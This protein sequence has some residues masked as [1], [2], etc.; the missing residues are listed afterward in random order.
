MESETT[1]AWVPLICFKQ[2]NDPSLKMT[3]VLSENLLYMMFLLLFLLKD[4]SAI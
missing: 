3:L 1:K 4:C 2:A